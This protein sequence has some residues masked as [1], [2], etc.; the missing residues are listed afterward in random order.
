MLSPDSLTM[1]QN[2]VQII[3]DWPEPCKVKDIQ[4]FLGFTNFYCHFIHEYSRIVIPLMHL[5]R[6]NVPWNFT[7]EC[8]S[9]FNTLKKAFTTTLVLTHWIPDT[10]I[11][12]KTDVSDYVLAAI[13]SIMTPSGELYPIAFHSQTF[14]TPECNYNVHDKE[15]LAIIEAF[16]RWRHYLEGSG[17]PIDVVTDHWNLQYFSTTK[18][19]T[20][21][22]A[23][24]S[25]FLSTFNLIIC[26]RPR[27][28]GTKPDALT[29]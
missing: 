13:L 26:F 4:S 8:H 6:K 11:M 2:K 27:K 10:Q 24:W 17:T 12:V 25:E 18:I 20:C 22:Q 1:A 15:L 5:T 29:R 3:Q 21:R 16:T 23:R 28:L 14:K 19:L 7:D 9:A